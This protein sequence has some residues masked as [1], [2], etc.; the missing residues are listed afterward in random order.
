[1][2]D[3]PSCSRRDVIEVFDIRINGC[4]EG[5][6]RLEDWHT[7]VISIEKDDRELALGVLA[8]LRHNAPQ[9]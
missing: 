7:P 2:I 1:M 4:R 6:R 3:N 5:Q 8:K 9:R